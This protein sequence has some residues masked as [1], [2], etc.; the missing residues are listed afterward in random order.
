VIRSCKLL[1]CAVAVSLLAGCATIQELQPA[2]KH[3][4]GGVFRVESATAWN[5]MKTG[6]GEIWTLNGFGLERMAFITKVA[7]G[8][9]IL[10]SHRDTGAPAF[11][12]DMTAT[13]VVDLYEAMLTSNGYSQI[14]VSNLHPLTVSGQNAFRFDYAAFDDGGLAKR[15]TVLGFIDQDK[16]LNLALYEAAA[17]H[18]YEASRAEAE[19]VLGSLEKI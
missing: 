15:G 6:R 8:E 13:D 3:D 19:Q 9:P 17:E 2:K 18:Y 10:L 1:A 14:D 4:I 11:R 16:G 5:A 7:D 12:A